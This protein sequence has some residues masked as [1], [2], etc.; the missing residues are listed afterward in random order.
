MSGLPTDRETIL[1]VRNL[2]TYF[3]TGAGL[4]RAVDGVS[5]S[6]R[7][8]ETLALVGESG[9]G[10]SITSLSIMQLVPSPPGYVEGGEVWFK[11]TDLL[12]LTPEEM[13]EVRGG[14]IAM[15]FQEPLTSLNPV[16][17]IGNQIIEALDL[18]RPG[19]RRELRLR[20]VDA[21]RR[22]GLPDPEQRL[23]NYPHQLSGGQRQRVMI[24]MALA[25][26]PEL[27]IADEPTTALD[28]TIQAQILR[29][30]KQLQQDTGMALMLITHDLGVVNQVADQVA[31]M[32]A[33]QVVERASRRDL[34]RNPQH[35]YTKGLLASLPGRT[36]RGQNLAA[37]P[38]IVPR[39]TEW[40]TGCR[41]RTRCGFVFEPCPLAVPALMETAEHH[42]AR[43][44][45]YG[46]E[47]VDPPA[48]LPESAR[49]A[50]A[51]D[52]AAP[53]PSSPDQACLVLEDRPS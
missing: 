50:P 44:Y 1:D 26:E 22:V 28:V 15:I 27:L 4:A 45:L 47:T 18:H 53:V 32:Y 51:P 35:P 10:K 21:L 2:R 6:I 11:G 16:F 42:S 17:T 52:A 8:G 3:R 20:A 46:R 34:F 12:D 38:G 29:L 30:L 25:C 43:C 36:R 14:Q 23:D 49:L 37:I 7:R 41:F 19:S 33:G 9:C 31:V 24:A 48:A 39:A 5:F 13:R 40:P